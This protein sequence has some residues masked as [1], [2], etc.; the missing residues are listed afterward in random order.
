MQADSS[1]L[2]RVFD[3]HDADWCC[4]LDERQNV[5]ESLTG[6]EAS[7]LSK[8]R[9]ASLLAEP[10]D[11]LSLYGVAFD[12]DFYIPTHYHDVDQFLIVISGEFR[13]GKH[14]LRPGHGAFMPAGNP[15]N[16]T[17]GRAGGS[18]LEFRDV[19]AYRTAFSTQDAHLAGVGAPVE[20]PGWSRPESKKGKTV[21]FDSDTCQGFESAGFGPGD[22]E[23]SVPAEIMVGARYQ[24]LH[25]LAAG[26][27]MISVTT[28]RALD[29][30]RHQQD[31]DKIVYVLAGAMS[32]GTEQ[33]ALRSGSGIFVPAM[34]PV[35]FSAGPAGVKYL[36]FRKQASWRTAWL[37]EAG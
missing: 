12:P 15:Y 31:A 5:A 34:T 2:L 7:Y 27:S 8:I 23:T 3:A 35:Q 1:N 28:D 36:E 24:A 26:Y 37:P 18:F 32:L 22:L 21:F 10:P 20:I 17:V 16:V 6:R 4:L 19:P 29:F 25:L 33:A 14:R 11:R 13:M 30:P 9:R